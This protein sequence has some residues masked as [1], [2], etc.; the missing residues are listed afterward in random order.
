MEFGD[1]GDGGRMKRSK[2]ARATDLSAKSRKEIM[3]RD[4]GRCIFCVAGYHMGKATP[5]EMELK[6]IMHYIPRSAGGLGIPQNAAVG[7]K[8]H[9]VMYDNGNEGRHDEMKGIFAGYL[10]RIYAGWNEKDLVYNK[11]QYLEG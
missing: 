11:W 2:R 8:Y 9:H 7:C 1:V 6:E 4:G 3:I 5:L 10:S